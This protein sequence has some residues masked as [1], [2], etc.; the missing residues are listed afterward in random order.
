MERGSCVKKRKVNRQVD[1]EIMPQQIKQTSA[2][3]KY[4]QNRSFRLK[5]YFVFLLLFL[6][7]SF[8]K[9]FASKLT[10]EIYHY[11]DG[12]TLITKVVKDYPV[13]ACRLLVRDGSVNE[14]PK[15]N[16]ISHLSEHMF[17][18]GTTTMN[19][20]QMKSYIENYGGQIN[21][22][23]YQDYTEFIANIPSVYTS[24][25]VWYLMDGFLHATLLQS[26]LHLE[27]KPV[28]DE[29]SLDKAN[30]QRQ[31]IELFQKEMFTDFPY[32]MPVEGF[33]STVKNITRADL[34]AWH[35][36]FYVPAN[37]VLVVVGDIHPR[38]IRKQV[39]DLLKGVPD[40]PFKP[41]VFRPQTPHTAP[42]V[43]EEVKKNIGH[44]Y[45]ALGYLVP[46]LNTPH[47]IYPTDVLTFLLGYGQFS[48]LNKELKQK[49]H[50]VQSISA[51]FLTQP[52]PG[53][54]QI[55]A[56]CHHG[57]VEKCKNKILGIIARVKEG[58]VTPEELRLAKRLLIGV[59]NLGNESDSGFAST[60]G[61][62]A[63]MGNP[64]FAAT[65]AD[66]IKKVTLKQVQKIADEYLK[67]NYVEVVFYPFKKTKKKPLK[68]KKKPNKS[69]KKGGKW[70]HP[71]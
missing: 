65:Y 31:L 41:P 55:V 62:Y 59:Y 13:A 54:L 58:K 23:T 68:F 71:E 53:T 64:E 18:R 14:N 52:Y 11:P 1:I 2:G 36:R 50:L 12:F 29:V 63:I 27:R 42:V 67:N 39:T 8:S 56:V 25:A 69:T 3:E 66:H 30:P 61:F 22:E 47:Q 51:N 70:G 33:P 10:F 37:A 49:D 7:L 20:L 16:G 45:L 4:A 57:D 34:L 46:G 15:I 24:K 35:K 6:F 43:V 48:L 60:I 21:G 17:F 26:M 28:L 40:L 32:S 38:A 44:P 5:K 19:D 9:S